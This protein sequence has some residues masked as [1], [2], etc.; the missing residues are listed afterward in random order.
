MQTMDTLPGDNGFSMLYTLCGHQEAV[1]RLAAAA[2][3]AADRNHSGGSVAERV[4]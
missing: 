2:A 3:A 1:H 4:V